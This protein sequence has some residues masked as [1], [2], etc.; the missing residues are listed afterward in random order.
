MLLNKLIKTLF[1]FFCLSIISASASLAENLNSDIYL[2]CNNTGTDKYKYEILMTQELIVNNLQLSKEQRKDL[3]DIFNLYIE[4]YSVLANDLAENKDIYKKMKQ[5]K[6]SFKTKHLQKRKI[7][8]LK[9]EVNKLQNKIIKETKNILTSKQ[10][11]KYKTI[12]K[13]IFK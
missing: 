12:I 8:D 2:F 9:K 13:S 3:E 1:I 7:N 4:D 6:A 11:A 5:D 10:R